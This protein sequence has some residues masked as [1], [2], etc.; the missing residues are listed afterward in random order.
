MTLLILSARL[1]TLDRAI[2]KDLSVRPSVV[3]T[4]DPRLNGNTVH[5]YDKP[6]FLSY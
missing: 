4:H 1:M 3:H 5:I 2:A 6:I